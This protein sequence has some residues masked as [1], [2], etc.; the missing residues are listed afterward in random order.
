MAKMW[1]YFVAVFMGI[2][3]SRQESLISIY[4]YDRSSFK[5]N[6]SKTGEGFFKIYSV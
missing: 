1:C 3:D 2:A 4:S 6:I 5:I